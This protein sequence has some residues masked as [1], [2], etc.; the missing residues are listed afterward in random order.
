MLAD[1]AMNA[2]EVAQYLGIGKNSVYQLAKSGQLASYHLG[3]KLRF[4]LR[5]VNAYLE[6]SHQVGG[7]NGAVARTF[8][9]PMSPDVSRRAQGTARAVNPAVETGGQAQTGRGTAPLRPGEGQSVAEAAQFSTAIEAPF[10]IAGGEIAGDVIANYLIS[11]GVNVS[12]TYQNSYTALVNLYGGYADIALSCL[13]DLRSNSYNVQYVR[14]LVPGVS[15]VVLRLYRRTRGFIVQRRNPR[16]LN[17]WGSLLHEGVRLANSPR[18]SAS[19]VLLDEKLRSLEARAEDIAGYADEMLTPV[20]AASRVAIGA[21]DVSV[22]TR[23]DA[24][25]VGGVG[26]VP[27]QTECIDL[28]IVKNDRTRPLIRR[29]KALLADDGLRSDLEALEHGDLSGIGGIAY[30][31]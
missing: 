15:V 31:S 20:E 8:S 30:E 24:H 11:Q 10:V 22:G 12:R 13:Y 18:G 23:R 17:A 3:R 28:T 14:R 25:M 26:F 27:L 9:T 2:E 21:A 1:D 19:R 29:I 16:N 5:D 6:A 7:G 4:T